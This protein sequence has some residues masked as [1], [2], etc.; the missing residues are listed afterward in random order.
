MVPFKIEYG[1]FKIEIFRRG[2]VFTI[3]SLIFASGI[4]LIN[5]NIFL[6]LISIFNKQ[7]FNDDTNEYGFFVGVFLLILSIFLFYLIIINWRIEI[8]SKTFVE[9]RKTLDKY[10]T[11]INF[12]LS[13]A[14]YS[15]LE[16]LHLE[17]YEQYK[18]TV[19]FLSENQTN[20]DIETYNSAR[21]LN[22]NIG[23]KFTELSTYIN[24]I[25]KI[26]N[27]EK[28]DFGYNPELANKGI[29]DELE[30]LRMQMNEFVSL[31]KEKEKFKILNQK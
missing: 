22:F 15:E 25:K 11:A 2:I 16:K 31:I 20:L 19:N 18:K 6:A 9:L 1:K 8:Y 17:A 3:A 28:T 7:L 26:E 4:N 12:R 30:D 13:Y 24:Q 5:G 23:R 10:G 27:K 21:E 14:S 29:S